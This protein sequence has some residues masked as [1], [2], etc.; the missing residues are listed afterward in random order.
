MRWNFKEGL[1]RMRK[2]N[3]LDHL[4]HKE[5]IW[6]AGMGLGLAGP[7]L[8]AAISSAGGFGVLGAGAMPASEI[9]SMIEATKKLTKKAS[10]C[11]YHNTDVGR[12]RRS[13]LL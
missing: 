13:R 1:C 9:K 5:P 10:W 11:K 8:V 12:I 3:M 7:D 4:N 6:N 2:R